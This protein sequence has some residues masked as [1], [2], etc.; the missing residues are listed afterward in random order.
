MVESTV[1]CKSS[2][3]F[4]ETV[5]E[6]VSCISYEIELVMGLYTAS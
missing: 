6:R 1:A 2:G 4:M 3:I 5:Y